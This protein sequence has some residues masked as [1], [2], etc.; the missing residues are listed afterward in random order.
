MHEYTEAQ[1]NH[2]R[3]EE[4]EDDL[5][6]VLHISDMYDRPSPE[7][8]IQ[9]ILPTRASA[10][11]YGDDGTCK[12]GL[13]GEIVMRM[14]YGLTDWFGTELKPGVVVIVAGEGEDNIGRMAQAFL[15]KYS[16]EYNINRHNQD[17]IIIPEGVA[18]DNPKEVSKLAQTLRYHLHGRQLNMII[19]DTL[20]TCLESAD[21]T[22]NADMV[23]VNRHMR[24]LQ[25][26]FECSTLIVHHSGKDPK[27]GMRGASDLR[28]SAD[29]VLFM[30]HMVD[31]IKGD[32]YQVT[33]EKLKGRVLPKEKMAFR[34]EIIE[35]D[36]Q[37]N[38]GDYELGYVLIP[39]SLLLSDAAQ[40][41]R[42]TNELLI[43][44]LDTAGELNSS[45]FEKI[46]K[47]KGISRT[48]YTSARDYLVSE[49]K[50][51]VHKGARNADIFSLSEEMIGIPNEQFTDDKLDEMENS[52]IL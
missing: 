19:F 43:T 5:Y 45:Q 2:R 14:A 9:K 7:W 32:V 36:T 17:L 22:K 40:Q 37:D 24:E 13:A 35:L 21:D 26:R 33:I 39:T 52:N 28:R 49:G 44:V 27:K 4:E 15:K 10:Y 1:N 29:V 51:T 34:Q 20:S 12:T 8:L 47:D 46:C 38:F 6:S 23:K 30:E 25:R 50:I 42:D 11:L 48:K 31:A 3:I 41:M 18:I 16:V